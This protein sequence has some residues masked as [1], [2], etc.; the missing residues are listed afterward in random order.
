MFV[1]D[2]VTFTPG[3]GSGSYSFSV[4]SGT[5][6]LV[7]ATYTTAAAETSTIRLR[8]T[9]TL[10]TVN[11]TVN[12]YY[13]V[14]VT[15]ATVTVQTNGNYPFTASG[16]LPP[17]TF[18]VFSGTGT[19]NASTGLFTAPASPES[20]TVKVVDSLGNAGTAT[21]TVQLPGLWN[22]VAI[23]APAKSGQYA[24]LALDGSGLPRIAYYEAQAKELRLATWNGSAWSVQTV[25]SS[26]SNTGQYCS[27][28]LASGTGYPR[29]SY[30]DA[31]NKDLRYAS[32]NGSSWALQTVDNSSG[33]I[34][35]YTCLALDPGTGYPRISY[36][37]T[38]NTNLKYA[39]WNGSSWSK[40]TVDTPGTVGLNTSLALDPATGYPR[41]SYYKSSTHDLR[42]ASWNGSSWVLTSVDTAGDVGK[43]TS[44]ALEPGTGYPHIS[45]YD[46]T[47]HAL[48]YASWNGAA[49][50]KSTVDSGDDVG[51]YTSLALEPGQ[52]SPASATT[53]TRPSPLSIY[54]GTER[55]GPSRPL[56]PPTTWAPTLPSSSIHL[57]PINR[58]S[59]TTTP[60]PRT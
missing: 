27:L 60:R 42:Y 4:V 17:Y 29:I 58:A 30:Y 52:C 25:D 55:F 2:A 32:W 48:K 47:N 51:M 57:F 19:I 38:S 10:G 28:A 5:G 3:G 45:Y 46:N 11:A 59:P 40:K 18:S 20:D 34:G 33:N 56:I 22:I 26:S 53:T 8:D 50:N 7:G 16:G 1:G 43:Y 54:G 31:H 23:D 21:V 6:S 44:L 9:I 24:S 14:T 39:A 36:Y 49:W 35:Q 41:I 12:S 13:P 15:P 37:D